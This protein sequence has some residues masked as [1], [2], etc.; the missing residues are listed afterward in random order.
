ML[1][2]DSSSEI[3]AVQ[4]IMN[5]TVLNCTYEHSN[6]SGMLLVVI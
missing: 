2:P 1:I 3:H 5:T 6:F 4:A